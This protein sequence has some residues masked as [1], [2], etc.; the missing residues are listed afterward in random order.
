MYDNLS[1]S[2]VNHSFTV[3][4]VKAFCMTTDVEVLVTELFCLKCVFAVLFRRSLLG[5]GFDMS[6][7]VISSTIHDGP[8]TLLR[9][10]LNIH[11]L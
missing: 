5:G 4:R 2:R 8:G 6:N 10:H 1:L 11:W 9:T 3:C 7:D